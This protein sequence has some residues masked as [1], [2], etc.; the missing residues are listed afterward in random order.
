MS[1]QDFWEERVLKNLSDE[2]KDKLRLAFDDQTRVREARDAAMR[3]ALGNREQ[4][5]KDMEA[6]SKVE[7]EKFK[8][9]INKELQRQVQGLGDIVN[10]QKIPENATPAERESIEEHN[11]AIREARSNFEKFFLDT[12]YQALVTKS[13]GGL[14]LKHMTKLLG[15]KDAKIAAAD[16]RFDEV[17]K[18]WQASLKSANTSHRQSV[19]QQA[20]PVKGLEYERNDGLRMEKMMQELPG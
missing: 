5:F 2:N 6:Q 15:Q 8:V 19:Q 1:H 14:L 9:E 16:A 4:Y 3:H 13:L 11:A 12:S 17:N 18:K 20:A 7:Q 10:E